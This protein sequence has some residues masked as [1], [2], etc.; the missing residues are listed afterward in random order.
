MIH[1][2]DTEKTALEEYLYPDLHYWQN[3]F[4]RYEY[5]HAHETNIP[6]DLPLKQR[7]SA[8]EHNEYVFQEWSQHFAI[9]HASLSVKSAKPT[10]LFNQGSKTQ[11][12]LRQLFM[13]CIF[14]FTLQK[15]PSFIHAVY[16]L[17]TLQK[18]PSFI[19]AVYTLFTL[20]RDPAFIHAVFIFITLQKDPA[21]IHAVYVIIYTTERSII[22]TCRVK[23]RE[24]RRATYYFASFFI[25]ID[26]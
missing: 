16:I 5:F 18:D 1:S 23:L 6:S 26:K 7:W 20:Q 3:H 8:V 17:L 22:Y 21:F 12:N 9:L 10:N 14:L 19:S 2:V 4:R 24:N 25:Q 11:V 15:E 13:P